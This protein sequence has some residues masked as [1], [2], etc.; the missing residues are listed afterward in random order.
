MTETGAGRRVKPLE[1][2]FDLVFVFAITQVTGLMS[3]DPTWGG[4]GRGLLALSAVWWA[5]GAYS[6]LTTTIDPDAAVAKLSLFAAMTAMLIVALATPQA[7]GSDAVLFACAYF[8]V[9]ALHIVVYASAS[10]EVSVQAAVR[11]LAP[12]S[13]TAP[14]LLI[15][16]GFLDGPAQIA[17]WCVA[18][19]ID[20]AGPYVRGVEGLVVSPLHFAERYGLI[21][22]IALGESIIAVGVGAAGLEL[23]A[24]EIAAA[25]AGLAIAGAM[26]WAYFDLVA[27]LAERRLGEAVGHARARLA[28]DAYSYLHLPMIAGIVLV[29]L[30]IKTTLAHVDEPLAAVPAVALCAGVSLYLLARTAFRLRVVG[31]LE[32]E[33]IVA[34][35]AAAA[36]IP[37]AVAVPALVAVAAVAALLALLV[38][39]EAVGF[40]RRARAG[41][42]E[43]HTGFEPVPPP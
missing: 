43:A 27:P 25:A 35:V 3:A 26:W 20:Y 21:V 29:A 12:T 6:W 23:G 28:R 33:R 30:A 39:H 11:A 24:G 10:E 19:A 14:V 13:I 40:R 4:V 7:F 34:A 17:L 32:T 36:L 42:R 38:S 9:R 37:L 22:I 2:F 5:W 31:T 16:A 1:L 8:V 41:T 15:A 18:L